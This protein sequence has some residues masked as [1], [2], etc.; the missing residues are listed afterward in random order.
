MGEWKYSTTILDLGIARRWMIGFSRRP[1]YHLGNSSRYPLDRMLGGPQSQ[2]GRCGERKNVLS[3]QGIESQPYSPSLYRLS[4]P[5][6]WI[7]SLAR[8]KSFCIPVTMIRTSDANVYVTWCIMQY[9]DKT[10]LVS[11]VTWVDKVATCDG[12]GAFPVYFTFRPE[13]TSRLEANCI[14]SFRPK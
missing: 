5:N 2:S 12:L 3:L 6:S 8:L 14:F 9:I 4:Y 7:W 10:K 1:C 11:I 13:F